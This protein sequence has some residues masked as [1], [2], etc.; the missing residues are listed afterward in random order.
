MLGLLR[1][2]LSAPNRQL[3]ELAFVILM[4]DMTA[5]DALADALEECGLPVRC[6]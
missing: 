3:Q 4:G 6:N 5:W 2:L 1:V